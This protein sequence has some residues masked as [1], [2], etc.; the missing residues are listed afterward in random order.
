MTAARA[1]PLT[2]SRSVCSWCSMWMSEV[3]MK[4][5]MRGRCGVLDRPPGGVDVGLVGAGQAADRRALDPAGDRLDR[6]EVA[7]RGDR[8]AGLDHVDAQTRQLLGDLHLLGG[9]E[10]DAGRLLAVPQRGVEDVD[11]VCVSLPVPLVLLLLYFVS[12]DL[13]SRG[14][15]AAQRYSPRGGRRRRSARLSKPVSHSLA[16]SVAQ[17]A[18]HRWRFVGCAASSPRHSA[19]T[20]SPSSPWGSPW[21]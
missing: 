19:S 2:S 3:E 1:W 18:R 7:G 15:R 14:Y 6:L 21:S 5:W 10:R 12:N 17:D 16:C 13:V 8:E 4:V 9:V 20:G 11:A